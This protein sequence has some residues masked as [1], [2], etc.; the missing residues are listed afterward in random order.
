MLQGLRSFRTKEHCTYV[1]A[2]S[3][4]TI[5]KMQSV[6]PARLFLLDQTMIL[7][8]N[9]M[10]SWR[11]RQNGQNAV[12]FGLGQASQRLLDQLRDMMRPYNLFKSKARWRRREGRQKS[13]RKPTCQRLS[14]SSAKPSPR[15]VTSPCP[16]AEA[17]PNFYIHPTALSNISC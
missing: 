2:N 16:P 8:V 13:A 1:K 14:D 10:L 11:P 7:N 15:L 12:R 5:N 9:D 6:S 3:L 17:H 4:N